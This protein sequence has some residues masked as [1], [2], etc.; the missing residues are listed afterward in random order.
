MIGPLEEQIGNTIV[1]VKVHLGVMSNSSVVIRDKSSSF[2]LMKLPWKESLTI[3]FLLED[4]SLGR[5]WELRERFLHLMFSKC[6]QL[7]IIN[8][9]KSHNWGREAVYFAI[10][11][12][13]HRY[14]LFNKQIIECPLPLP[15]LVLLLL[16]FFFF[17]FFC[18]H[19][20]TCFL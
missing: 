15:F 13:K 8:T 20:P 10:L 12:T 2:L 18:F 14:S 3:E 4:L 1:C 9:P 19:P 7:K 11:P 17:F 6:L 16:F 5:K